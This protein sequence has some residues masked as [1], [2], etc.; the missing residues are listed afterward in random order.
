MLYA[1]SPEKSRKFSFKEGGGGGL[2]PLFPNFLDPPLD[3]DDDDDEVEVTR[4]SN[5]VRH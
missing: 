1:P 5:Q 4:P 3:D 2:G